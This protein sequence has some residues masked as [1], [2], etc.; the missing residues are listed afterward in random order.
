[1][2]RPARRRFAHCLYRLLHNR[3]TQQFAA[4]VRKP[5]QRNARLQKPKP[6]HVSSAIIGA[7]SNLQ[8]QQEPAGDRALLLRARAHANLGQYEEATDCCRRLMKELPFA[9]EPYELLASIAQEQ[10]RYDE[11]KRC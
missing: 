5:C 4:A 3:L 2:S 7:D 9:S 1:M 6:F 10:G 8:P 11:A